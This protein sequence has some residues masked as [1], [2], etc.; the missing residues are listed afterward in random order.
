MNTPKEQQVNAA[1]EELMSSY[2]AKAF[3]DEDRKHATERG[4]QAFRGILPINA[5]K[6]KIYGIVIPVVV[7]SSPISHPN[8]H[9]P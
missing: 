3:T 2:E 4:Y 5:G 8:I 7:G 9:A 6:Y 1:F